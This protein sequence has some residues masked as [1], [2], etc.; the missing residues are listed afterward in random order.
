MHGVPQSNRINPAHQPNCN[1]YLGFPGLAPLRVQVGSSSLAYG[2][3]IYPHPTQDSLITF[4]HPQGDRQAFLDLLKPV[5]YVVSDLGISLLS[6][7]F[8]T[9]VGFFSLDVTNRLDGHI[10]YPGDLARLVLNGAME[11]ETYQLDGIGADIS[12]FDE[13]L[14]WMVSMPFLIISMWVPGRKY[15]LELQVFP[16]PNLNSPS[17]PPRT[18]WNIQSDMNIQ[19][20]HSLCGFPV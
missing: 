18:S 17:L 6:V 3:V 20:I 13:S 9:A 10:Y 12:A 2:D 1:F 7:G 4:L 8:R 11:G 14:P 19:C 15:C 5:N 16:Q